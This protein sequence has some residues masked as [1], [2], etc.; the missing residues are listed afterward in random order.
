MGGSNILIISQV[1]VT[2]DITCDTSSQGT[3]PMPPIIDWQFLEQFKIFQLPVWSRD[4]K[5]SDEFFSAILDVPFWKIRF[6]V[7]LD[8]EG[9]WYIIIMSLIRR[10]LK[11]HS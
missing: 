6:Y 7:L 11:E 2:L 5:Q 9:K 1:Y 4:V 8:R 10:W 3:N